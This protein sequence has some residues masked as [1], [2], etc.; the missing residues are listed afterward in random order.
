MHR[1]PGHVRKR[2][3]PIDHVSPKHRTCGKG[4]PSRP[5]PAKGRPYPSTAIPRA[6]PCV[7]VRAIPPHRML[8]HLR[9]HLDDDLRIF[10]SPQQRVDGRK[11][12]LKP[13]ID[14]TSPHRDDRARLG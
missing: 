14:D 12:V 7:G 1:P 2:F 5:A 3:A 11:M 4:F 13:D 6:S 10:S 8:V 9:P